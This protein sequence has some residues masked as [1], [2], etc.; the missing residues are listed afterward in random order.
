MHSKQHSP[1]TIHYPSGPA[2]MSWLSRHGLH[3]NM[4]HKDTTLS[5]TV[6]MGLCIQDT[7]LLITHI[8]VY[9]AWFV[10]QSRQL[11]VCRLLL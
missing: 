10:K 7:T 5:V 1:I 9:I 3:S 11:Y 8:G 2:I 4:D 6:T